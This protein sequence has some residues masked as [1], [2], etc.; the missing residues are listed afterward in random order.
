MERAQAD[1]WH[2]TTIMTTK[3]SRTQEYVLYGDDIVQKGLFF[4][5]VK[6]Q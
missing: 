3:E 6:L 2:I 1:R 4:I 5:Y